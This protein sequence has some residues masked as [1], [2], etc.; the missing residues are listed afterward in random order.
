ML[1]KEINILSSVCHQSQF[2]IPFP[3]VFFAKL[4]EQ[5]VEIILDK[6]MVLFRF[7]QEKDMF[8]R[9]YKQHLGRR[10]LS[11]KS[12]SDDLEKNMISKLKVNWSTYANSKDSLSDDLLDL[13][14]RHKS[15]SASL[16]LIFSADRMWLP[17]YL[18]TGGD[19]QRHEY[20]QH[21]NGRV[22]AAHSNY[23]GKAARHP[24][25]QNVT[26]NKAKGKHEASQKEKK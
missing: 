2:L 5:E 10:L 12:V 7:L 3:P 22:Q 16:H 19:V 20:L 9:Y 21:N 11:N 15:P 25:E 8:E 1:F 13:N 23:V 4:T 26:L 18:Q 17:V 6:T 14:L 24:V